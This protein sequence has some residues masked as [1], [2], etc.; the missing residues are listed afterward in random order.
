[1]VVMVAAVLSESFGLVMS[2]HSRQ[3]KRVIFKEEL[4]PH[5]I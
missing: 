4:C 3:Q 1:M 2:E 5:L